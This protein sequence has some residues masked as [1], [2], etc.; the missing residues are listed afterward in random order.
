MTSSSRCS[1]QSPF[2]TKSALNRVTWW[3]KSHDQKWRQMD[4]GIDVFFD[5]SLH[6]ETVLPDIGVRNREFPST[7][8]SAPPVNMYGTTSLSWCVFISTF[9]Y[10]KWLILEL[11]NEW[12]GSLLTWHSTIFQLYMWRHIDV[13]A[14][15]RSWTYGRVPTP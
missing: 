8:S 4:P 12:I 14:G 7:E 6:T 1:C 11:V 3:W 10:E 9:I 2:W 5:F 13:K 15:C